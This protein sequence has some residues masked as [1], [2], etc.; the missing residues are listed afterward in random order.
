MNTT[1]QVIARKYRPQ[2][3]RD[4]VGQES[5]VRILENSMRM[6]RTAHAYLMVG[7]RGVGKTSTARIAAM[8]FN[9]PEKE[10]GEYDASKGDYLEIAEG[11]HPDVLELDAATHSGVDLIRHLLE[12][13]SFA[14]SRLRYRIYL[15]DEVHML[16]LS[17]FNAL[18]K[19]LEE[20]PPRVKFI[21]AT[22]E[23][24]KVPVTIKSRCQWLNL[25]LIP[26]E[27]IVPALTHIAQAEGFTLEPGAAA[28]LAEASGGSMRDAQTAL[29]QA[30]TFTEGKITEKEVSD[31]WG[32][33]PQKEV[34][35][36]ADTI[37]C[38]AST[39]LWG[40]LE[41]IHSQGRDYTALAQSLLLILRRV[42]REIYAPANA[43]EPTGLSEKTSPRKLLQI[44]GSLDGLVSRMETCLDPASLFD[45]WALEACDQSHRPDLIDLA[46]RLAPE[47]KAALQ[48]LLSRL[49]AE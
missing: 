37:L 3:L 27:L 10:G 24:K 1:H 32:T 7:P 47:D 17:A 12:E 48:A 31:L 39:P 44:V 40:Q 16:S 21:L 13:S 2:Y 25:R 41:S 11:R 26:E 18:L 20:P 35:Q 34:F 30:A 43:G 46:E 28:A 49:E 9:A 42:Q 19:T 33:V 23:A 15:I 14:P 36:L 6:G 8:A 4:L 22:T 29:E 45:Q 38:G 5:V